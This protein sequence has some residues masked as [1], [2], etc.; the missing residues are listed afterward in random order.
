MIF[1]KNKNTNELIDT[2]ITFRLKV[3]TML[4]ANDDKVDQHL[5]IFKIEV[6][7][8]IEQFQRNGSDWTLD[9][10][11]HLDLCIVQYDPLRAS[12]YIVFPNNVKTRRLALISK[13]MIINVFYG[14]FFQVC[15][16]LKV[17]VI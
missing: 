5:Q 16:M 11:I 17:N 14:V 2:P 9:H 3:F 7:P 8:F 1:N 10:F 4:E 6:L 12:K 15:N 13:I